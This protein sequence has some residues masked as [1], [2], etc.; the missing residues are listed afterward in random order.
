MKRHGKKINRWLAREQQ[1]QIEK[2]YLKWPVWRLKRFKSAN[3]QQAGSYCDR[4]AV[5]K[6]VNNASHREIAVQEKPE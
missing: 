4:I 1:A 3:K 6:Q 2:L 5:T